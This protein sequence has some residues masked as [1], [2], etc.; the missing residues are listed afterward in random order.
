MKVVLAGY[1]L[2]H[3]IVQGLREGG[4]DPRAPVSPETIPAAYARISRYPE[5]VTELREKARRDVEAA[6]RSNQVIVFGMG[7][8]S[9][10]EHVQVNFD[11]IGVSRLALEALEEAR[12]CSYTEKSQRYVT[13]DGDYV[14]PAE[15]GQAERRILEETVSMQVAAYRDALPRLHEHHR[16]QNPDMDSTPRDR[17]I[18][19]GWAK[20]DA[21]YALGL[22]TEAQLGFSANA[23]N[24]EHVIRKL[25]HGPLAEVRDLSRLLYEEASRVVPSLIILS[26]PAKFRETFGR[27]VSDDHLENAPAD[28]RAATEGLVRSG[29]GSRDEPACRSGSV[30]LVDHS[31]DPDVEVCASLMFSASER[32]YAECVGLARNL[33]SAGPDRFEEYVLGSMRRLTEYDPPPRAF[34]TASFT[35]EMELSASAFAQLKRHRMATQIK[36][37]YDPSLA[38]TFPPSLLNTGLAPAFESVYARS[39]EAHRKVSRSAGRSAAEYLL[40]NGHRRRVLF[41]CNMRE[42]YHLARIRMDH[43]AQWDI[44]RISADVVECVRK[45]APVSARLA[46]GKDSYPALRSEVFGPCTR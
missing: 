46:T 8:H 9:V 17:T 31:P 20:E 42:V 4:I 16:S 6:R 29:G 26:D 13:L 40:A 43:H 15:Y 10:A 34:E 35:F 5:P 22:A 28:L 7:H 36:Q 45:V 27:D 24:L 25:R 44:R 30:S 11:I 14:I 32:P 2:D 12:L 19:E 33:R 38:C 39:A 3:E 1:S 18:V 23:R 21:R 41:A 37:P